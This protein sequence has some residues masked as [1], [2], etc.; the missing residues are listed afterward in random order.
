[1]KPIN[2]EGIEA[3]KSMGNNQVEHIASDAE[4]NV[5]L[6]KEMIKRTDKL[7]VA[8]VD[9]A[10][11]VKQARTFLEWSAHHMRKA[12]FEWMEE[13]QKSMKDLT[14]LRMAVERES[15]TTLAAAAD[16][17]QFFLD[18]KHLT[19]V[20]RLREF[21]ELLERLKKLKSDGTL[22]VIADTILRLDETEPAQ[23]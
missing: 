5:E 9:L 18:E 23:F 22:D 7:G 13:A 20:A 11:Q 6:T 8:S 17:R 3:T 10:I 21:V 15:K 12:W 16:V 4:F 14:M 2:L 1:M 19:Q